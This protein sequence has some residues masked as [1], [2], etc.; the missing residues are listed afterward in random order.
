MN[1]ARRLSPAEDG[2][3]LRDG[4]VDAGRHG[5]AGQHDE[6]EQ[7]EHH[8][9]IG[10]LLEHIVALSRFPAREAQAQMLDDVGADMTKLRGARQKVAPEMAAREAEDEIGKAVQHEEPGEEEVPP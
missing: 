1:E 5:E 6:R 10:E 7:H 4:G 2:K 3:K 8:R 9:E